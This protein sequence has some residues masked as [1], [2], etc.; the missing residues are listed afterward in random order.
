MSFDVS[1]SFPKDLKI[2]ETSEY[3]RIFGESKRLNTEHFIILYVPN[4]LG[5]SRAGFVVSKKSVPGAVG[6][7]RVKRVLREIFR[8]NKSL[9]GSMDYVFVAKK[10]SD[11][12]DYAQARLEIEKII[13]SK[14]S[15]SQK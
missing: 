5:Y 12:L 15:C 7:N 9:F 14:L 13:R 8:R 2:Q 11:S 4:S 1:F 3:E 6:R 10:G